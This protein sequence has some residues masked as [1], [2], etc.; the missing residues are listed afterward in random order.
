M[1]Y[2]QHIFCAARELSREVARRTVLTLT[3]QDDVTRLPARDFSADR[4]G[5]QYK[6]LF[7]RGNGILSFHRVCILFMVVEEGKK[8]EAVESD[9]AARM[10]DNRSLSILVG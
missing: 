4:L 7:V 6:E 9:E 5:S 10:M 8:Q 1:D 2:C 3:W